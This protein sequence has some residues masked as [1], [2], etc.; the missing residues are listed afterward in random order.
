MWLPKT[1]IAPTVTALSPPPSAGIKISSL[2]CPLLPLL[3][4]QDVHRPLL[5]RHNQ[6]QRDNR[7]VNDKLLDAPSS[8]IRKKFCV[9]PHGVA[10]PVRAPANPFTSDSVYA[11]IDLGYHSM[12]MNHTKENC[13]ILTRANNVTRT[14]NLNY[15]SNKTFLSHNHTIDHDN[16]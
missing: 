1:I 10:S 13:L 15:S 4:N 2:G 9:A 11:A 12:G 7:A 6:P 8:L 3:S 16:N 14:I 5:L